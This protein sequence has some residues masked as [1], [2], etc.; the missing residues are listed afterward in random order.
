LSSHRDS[1]R[2]DA[3][4]LR[5][6]ERGY[7]LRAAIQKARA[8]GLRIGLVPTMGALHDGHMSLVRTATAECDKTV[9]TIFVNPTQFGPG[10]DLG[11]YPRTLEADCEALAKFNVDLV[12][13]PSTPEM[14]PPGF[15]THVEPPSVAIPLEGECR[16]GHFRGVAT[17]VL[18]LFHLAP[19][20]VAFFG[21]KD[22][23]QL[24]VI[25]K[26]VRDLNLPIEVR[27]C[28]IVRE[29][30]GLAMSSRNR[31]LS[32]DQRQQALG[33]WR[34]LERASQQVGEG[35]KDTAAIEDT[36]R[37]TLAQHGISRIDYAVVAH[38]DTL[39]PMTRMDHEAV[40]LLAA[41]VGKTR[42]ID[43]CMLSQ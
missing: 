19:V 24:L 31:Y 30:D 11:Q 9:V 20:D 18:K 22:Y 10:E 17:V 38:P 13:V 28:P 34:S 26:M 27:R 41:F 14:Y 2:P 29:S 37:A 5:L 12:F 23:Q 33:L 7:D 43:N 3:R 32:T 40:A 42:L 39:E 8:D 35:E 1:N 25:R 6:I 4:R 36:M 16:P 15:S 21:Q